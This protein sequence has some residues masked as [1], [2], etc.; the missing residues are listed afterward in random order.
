MPDD[1]AELVKAGVQG[2]VE[3]SLKPFSDLIAALFGPAASEAGLMLQEHVRHSRLNRQ[4][5][6]FERTA[7][8]LRE[9]GVEPQRVDQELSRRSLNILR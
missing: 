7:A 2:M 3:G 6:L 9:A 8:R 1:D 4:V 5:R